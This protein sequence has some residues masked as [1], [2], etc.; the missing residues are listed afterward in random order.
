MSNNNSL[1]SDCLFCKLIAGK[2]PL[3]GLFWQNDQFM[4]WLAIDPSTEGFSV[5][6]PKKHYSSDVLKMPDRELNKFVLAAKKVAQGLESFFA[7]VGRI[8]LIMEGTGID[9]AHIKL[10]P[11]HNTPW[12]KSGIWKAIPSNKQEWFKAYP[13][14]LYSGAGPIAKSKNLQTLANKLKLNF[15]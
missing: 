3:D 2:L 7:D 12:M 6:V 4:A 10:I 8:G 11:M 5:V 1:Q 14:Y 13:G 9:H 15:I